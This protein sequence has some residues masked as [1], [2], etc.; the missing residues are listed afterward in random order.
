MKNLIQ[1]EDIHT[2]GAY[3]AVSTTG[4]LFRA[5]YS[6]THKNMFFAIP[7]TYQIAGY[8]PATL[9]EGDRVRVHLYDTAGREIVTRHFG[10][11]F[12][13]R[14][15]NSA[16]GI[17]W[18]TERSPYTCRGEIFAPFSTFAPSVIFEQVGTGYRFY[19][20]NLSDA[21]TRKEAATC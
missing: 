8:R 18:N 19:W 9:A 10:D 12:T 13:V 15:E 2:P 5:T 14:R 7:S 6:D 11:V 21:L 1:F 17:D 3:I 16:L 20:D 4:E